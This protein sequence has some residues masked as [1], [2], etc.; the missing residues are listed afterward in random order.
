VL[1]GLL[2]FGARIAIQLR[3]TG[4][5]G[6]NGLRGASGFAEWIAGL[7][8]ALAVVLCLA[9]PALQLAGALQS[10]R[11][12]DGEIANP[13]GAMVASLGIVLALAG[14]TLLL[15]ALELQTR[16]IEEPYLLKVHARRKNG[17]CMICVPG[18]RRREL[19]SH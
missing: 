6:V 1:Y 8:F 10:I 9:G 19:R 11:W 4:A 17:A 15:V 5:S 2:A 13:L 16:L 18:K 14:A 3:R 7:L 12:L